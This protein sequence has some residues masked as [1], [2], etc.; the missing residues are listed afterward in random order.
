MG[1]PDPGEVYPLFGAYDSA[2]Y[3]CRLTK[4]HAL[5]VGQPKRQD[6]ASLAAS[7]RCYLTD[8]TS[9]LAGLNIVGPSSVELLME[10]TQLDLSSRQ[11]GRWCS[12]GGLAKVR[13]IVVRGGADSFDVFFGRDYAEYVWDELMHLGKRYSL[14]P[15]G[16]EAHRLIHNRKEA[17]Q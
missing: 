6:I 14:S 11:G 3:A 8:L 13:A 4:E 10:M 17:T 7:S 5:I 16:V 12:E 1:R 9:V 15:F 2:A